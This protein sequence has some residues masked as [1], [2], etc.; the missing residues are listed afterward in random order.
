M[1]LRGM[2]TWFKLAKLE[3]STPLVTEI[4]SGIVT[5]AEPVRNFSGIVLCDSHVIQEDPIRGFS[6]VDI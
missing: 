1:G 4:H 5:Q 2:G 3:F 6:G